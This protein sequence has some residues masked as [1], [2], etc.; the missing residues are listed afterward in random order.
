[1]II[2]RCILLSMGNVPHKICVEN[3]NTNFICSNF[4][5]EIRVVYEIMWKW[6]VQ[7]ERPLYNAARALCTRDN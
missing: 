7:P 2:A 3:Q 1:M 6:V 4:F 5:S